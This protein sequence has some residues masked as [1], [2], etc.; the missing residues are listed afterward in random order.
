MYISFLRDLKKDSIVT[1][2]NV[3]RRKKSIYDIDNLLIE[4]CNIVMLICVRA[5][6][7]C[8]RLLNGD[9]L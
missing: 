2:Y 8:L 1:Q 3:K 5:R 6:D 7:A 4:N 9:S